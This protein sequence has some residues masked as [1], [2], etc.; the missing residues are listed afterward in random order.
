MGFRVERHGKGH[1][2]YSRSYG[3]KKKA[4]AAKKRYRGKRIVKS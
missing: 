2:K 4:E 3:S 1:F